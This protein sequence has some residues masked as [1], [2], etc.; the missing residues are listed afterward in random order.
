M[1]EKKWAAYRAIIAGLKT[2]K[3]AGL[4]QVRGLV[5]RLSVGLQGPARSVIEVADFVLDLFIALLLAIIGLAVGFIEGLVGLVNG[6]VKL[7]LGFLKMTVDYL[8][9]L[10]GKVRMNIRKM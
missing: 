5:P 8:V 9:S 2:T 10:M 3:N 1:D 6:L 4:N 7:A